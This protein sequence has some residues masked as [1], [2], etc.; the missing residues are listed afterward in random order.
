[1]PKRVE[2]ADVNRRFPVQ[3]VCAGGI[4]CLLLPPSPFKKCSRVGWHGHAKSFSELVIFLFSSLSHHA[5]AMGI[6]SHVYWYVLF[7]CFCLGRNCLNHSENGGRQ[8]KCGRQ[9]AK[10]AGKVKGMHAWHNAGNG[11]G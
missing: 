1:M 5:Y 4:P 11:V 2:V 7:F 8:R 6:G 3:C 9:Q 10:K